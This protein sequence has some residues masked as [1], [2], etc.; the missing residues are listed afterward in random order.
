MD[1]AYIRSSSLGTWK[2]CNQQYFFQ[3]V[4]GHNGD[5]NK[6]ADKGT[7]VHKVMEILAF[8]QLGLQNKEGSFEDDIVGYVN[9]HNYSIDDLTQKVYDYYTG[10]FTHHKWTDVDYRDCR[11][12]IQKCLEQNNGML[13][14]RNQH[15]IQPE[16]KFDITIDKPWAWYDFVDAEGG[17]VKGQLAIKGTIDLITKINDDTY[18]ITDYKTGRRLD[19]A[20]GEEKTIAKLQ[21]DP[22][23]M[24]YYYAIQHLY[25]EAKHIIV[26]INFIND[27]GI[28]SI[29]FEKGDLFKVEMMLRKTF[30]DIKNCKRPPLK[31]TWK[32]TKL[33]DFGKKTFAGTKHEPLVE[34]REDQLTP[35]GE[36]MTMCEQVKHDTRMHGIKE[37]VKVYQVDGYNVGKYRAP[38]S[39]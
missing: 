27:G 25:P 6:K 32:C 24:L 23:L 8:V 17:H 37:A 14:P 13:D 16:Q 36:V 11:K 26:T 15:I 34:Y 39:T 9:V 35:V 30:E 20:T 19:W 38:G 29:N 2:M 31:K 33:C 4:L 21:R 3:Y 5:S 18:E 28:F 1:I 10:A 7:I 22:Q 12:W